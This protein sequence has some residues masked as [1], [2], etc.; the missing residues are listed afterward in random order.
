LQEEPEEL[1]PG[2]FLPLASHLP[3][4]A[5]VQLEAAVVLISPVSLECP[6]L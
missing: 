6:V 1:P 2:F 3:P 4:Q 5:Q